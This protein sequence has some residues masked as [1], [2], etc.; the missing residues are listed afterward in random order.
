MCK[1]NV[2]RSGPCRELTTGPLSIKLPLDF[3]ELK[4]NIVSNGPVHSVQISILNSLVNL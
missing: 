4:P 3:E 2:V 1:G